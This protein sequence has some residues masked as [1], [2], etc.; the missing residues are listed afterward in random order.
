MTPGQF[1]KF[2][3][4]SPFNFTVLDVR[5]YFCYLFYVEGFPVCGTSL[6]AE[7]GDQRNCAV[8]SL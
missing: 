8:S 5:A 7:P 1:Q 3:A 6:R 2:A 4:W